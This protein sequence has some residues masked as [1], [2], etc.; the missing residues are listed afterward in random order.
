MMQKHAR[1]SCVIRHG[2]SASDHRYCSITSGAKPQMRMVLREQRQM[3]Q[4]N[5]EEDIC[6]KLSE[7]YPP[8]V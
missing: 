1:D 5:N 6:L 2:G 8:A 7:V 4:D 3:W